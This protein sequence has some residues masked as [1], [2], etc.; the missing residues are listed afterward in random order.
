MGGWSQRWVRVASPELLRG[1]AIVDGVHDITTREDWETILLGAPSYRGGAFAPHAAI[2]QR[3]ELTRGHFDR[4]LQLWFG[5]VDELFA[6]ETADLAKVHALRV[7]SA[8]HTRLQSF[9]SP[10]DP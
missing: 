7:A 2:H 5:T 4:W 1:H 10:A 9:P 6:G 3:A 8:F